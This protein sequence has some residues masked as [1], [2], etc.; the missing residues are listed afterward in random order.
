M[1]NLINNKTKHPNA[2][3][4]Y[5]LSAP[6]V[7]GV[8]M[9]YIEYAHLQKNKK[10]IHVP[11]K[12]YTRKKTLWSKVYLHINLSTYVQPSHS[13]TD[14]IDFRRQKIPLSTPKHIRSYREHNSKQM[15]VL[16]LPHRHSCMCNLYNF[17]NVY[18]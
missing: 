5:I 10:N 15:Y 17:F 8:C 3:L 11:K 18:Y 13:L 9:P 16:K 12:T 7:K 2:L 4:A 1:E 6:L 14:I